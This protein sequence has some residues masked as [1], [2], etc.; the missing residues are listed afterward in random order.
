MAMAVPR[1]QF[2]CTNIV[3]DTI[4]RIVSRINRAELA[5]ADRPADPM[6]AITICQHEQPPGTLHFVVADIIYLLRPLK[7]LVISLV[8]IVPPRITPLRRFNHLFT[9]KNRAVRSQGKG[10][11][12]ART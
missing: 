2:S 5:T 9:D 3:P 10:N 6:A 11:G 7:I 4:N 1:N 8:I 12:V